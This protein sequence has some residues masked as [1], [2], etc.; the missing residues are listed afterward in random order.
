MENL[1]I[2]RNWQE[3]DKN[4]VKFAGIV[5][6]EAKSRGTR[7]NLTMLF[8]ERDDINRYSVWIGFENFVWTMQII[9]R[10][11]ETTIQ[12]ETDRIFTNVEK[13]FKTNR[14]IQD[15]EKKEQLK[16]GHPSLKQKTRPLPCHL[17]SYVAISTDITDSRRDF[18]VYPTSRQYP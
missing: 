11:T 14:T 7:N 1:P 15:I 6:V 17:Q 5:T 16:P 10:T 8:T 4:E 2:T 9:E 12:S 13:L 18:V 3:V